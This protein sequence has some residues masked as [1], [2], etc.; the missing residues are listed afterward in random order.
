MPITLLILSLFSFLL[1]ILLPMFSMQTFWIFEHQFS[2]VGGVYQLIVNYEIL[3]AIILILF[4]IV[5]PLYK[6]YLM[7]R[8][9]LL[10]TTL[11]EQLRL[12]SQLQHIGKWSMAEVFVIAIFVVVF[13]VGSM[14]SVST[15]IGLYLFSA[16]IILSLILS[17]T[18]MKE[19]QWVLKDNTNKENNIT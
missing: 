16:S 13:K 11:E 5:L 1:G 2:I 9:V 8:Y 12:V 3:L 18:I 14:A 6:Y 4:S 7:G 17:H 19:Y 15:H 10:R